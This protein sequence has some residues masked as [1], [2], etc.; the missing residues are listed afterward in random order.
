MKNKEQVLLHHSLGLDQWDDEEMG[1]DD[2]WMVS[3]TD[4]FRT[5]EYLPDESLD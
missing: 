1:Y 2:N 4:L 5:F 3:A